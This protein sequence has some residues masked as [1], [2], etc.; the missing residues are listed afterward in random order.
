MREEGCIYSSVCDVKQKVELVQCEED[1]LE[2]NN[3]VW[4]DNVM[5][6]NRIAILFLY[7]NGF[8]LIYK[9]IYQYHGIRLG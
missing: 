5:R 9:K 8:G 2:S 3:I 6:R 7:E 1:A 4:P